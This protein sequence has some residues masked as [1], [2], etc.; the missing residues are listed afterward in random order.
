MDQGVNW[1]KMVI[2]F[3]GGGLGADNKNLLVVWVME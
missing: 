3:G 2:I 1:A